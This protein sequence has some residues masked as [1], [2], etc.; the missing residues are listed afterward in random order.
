MQNKTKNIFIKEDSKD[1]W[2]EPLKSIFPEAD[3]KL[4]WDENMLFGS[5]PKY[6]LDDIDLIICDYFLNENGEEKYGDVWLKE[7]VLSRDTDIPV[8][9]WTS[10]M[11][12]NVI[13]ST[14]IGSEVFF[15]KKLVLN[16]FKETVDRLINERRSKKYYPLYNSFFNQ[17]IKNEEYR[18]RIYHIYLQA[19][20]RLESFFGQS[21]YHAVFNAHG[22]IHIQ[23]VIDNL[24]TL[25]KY[26]IAEES[27]FF[28]EK[29]YVIVYL[30]ALLHDL[31][32]IPDEY[33]EKIEFQSFRKLREEHCLRIFK[34]INND[35][36]NKR[37]EL[38]SE[39]RLD[40]FPIECL[41]EKIA[42]LTLYH[43]ANYDFSKFPESS[44][45]SICSYNKSLKINYCVINQIKTDNNLKVLSGLLALA[46]KMDYGKTR[47]PVQPIRKSNFR[48]L[49]DEFE[50]TKNE[51]IKNC[52]IKLE[53]GTKK[54]A[55]IIFN[56]D[57]NSVKSTIKAKEDLFDKFK[58][59][60]ISKEIDKVLINDKGMDLIVTDLQNE[61]KE[62]SWANIKQAFSNS[63]NHFLKTI[64]LVIKGNGNLGLN[65][66][67]DLPEKNNKIKITCKVSLDWQE[68]A[69]MN[70]IFKPNKYQSLSI[71]KISEGF[72][73]A[74]VFYVKDISIKTYN[75][76]KDFY[77]GQNKF[78]KIG[79]YDKIHKEV[80]NYKNI[81]VTYLPPKSTIGHIEEYKYLDYGGYIGS[82][83]EDDDSTVT[84]L[85][86]FLKKDLSLINNYIKK[87]LEIFYNNIKPIKDKDNVI[88][89]Y[90][91]LINAKKNKI[92]E[93]KSQTD[94]EK[95]Y[96]KYLKKFETILNIINKNKKIDLHASIIHGD[97]T[98]KNILH[99][100][101][102]IV[103]ID[104][105]NSGWGHYFFDF[106][107]LEHNIINEILIKKYKASP[108]CKFK[109]TIK[110]VSQTIWDQIQI[111]KDN[112]YEIE[113]LFASLFMKL[114]CLKY[115]MK[116]EIPIERR[117]KEFNQNYK[118]LTEKINKFF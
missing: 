33:D 34:W 48:S 10:S 68:E 57:F 42:F 15:K 22:L 37:L 61:L 111:K 71:E 27:D 30:A 38:K 32:M 2:E 60:G 4:I 106:A 115:E 77:H 86:K 113:K 59:E 63:G 43:D 66:E 19:S 67:I 55:K 89:F 72:S 44:F 83:I 114:W 46:D 82:I 75:N 110:K 3:Y 65:R 91:N 16:K 23:R 50:Y 18:K 112:N 47:T 94:G 45:K 93:K 107:K 12:P 74:K 20:R 116:Y 79:K 98:F 6:N 76:Q 70:Y 90:T 101:N 69:L 81:A 95:Y 118:E 84:S 39:Y 14:I 80:K 100:G 31:G 21:K 51:V 104:F 24:A 99:T 96:L 97:F 103:F 88:K 7:K 41:K 56:L 35:K 105:A 108:S 17:K 29:D 62:K 53:N 26:V 40:S 54:G 36:I 5:D 73:G 109:N 64:D 49:R 78:L 8:V 102:N 11:N 92:L 117:V 87:S 52:E 9:F 85:E 28:N 1:I 13:K 25:I 58:R